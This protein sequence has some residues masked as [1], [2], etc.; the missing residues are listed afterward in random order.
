M[1][2]DD[3]VSALAAHQKPM[4]GKVLAAYERYAAMPQDVRS[5]ANLS[6]QEGTPGVRQLERYSREFAWAKR[7]ELVL[8]A[9]AGK[10]R[11]A[12]AER[13]DR[14]RSNVEAGVSKLAMSY[15]LEMSGI[16]AYCEGKRFV[17]NEKAVR[18]VGTPAPYEECPECKGTGRS[19]PLRL[20]VPAMRGVIAQLEEI[21]GRP[22]TQEAAREAD[23][24]ISQEEFVARQREMLKRAGLEVLDD[25]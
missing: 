3:G 25:M 1:A 24:G 12:A 10:V 20:N 7:I 15:A 8:E 19:N 2:A 14:L 23:S 17:A 18:V 5:F 4:P 16:C 13:R 11:F 21:W 9:E 6:A 22:V